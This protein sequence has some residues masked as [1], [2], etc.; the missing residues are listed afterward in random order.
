M[1]RV[2]FA[3]S[4]T[5][6]L[7][8]GGALTAVANRCFAD[9]QQGTFLLRIDDTD[10]E[11]SEVASEQ[12]ILDDLGWLGIEPDAAPIRQSERATLYAKAAA[13]LSE[14]G[15]AAEEDGALRA[16]IA[17]RPTLVRPGGSATYHLASPVDDGALGITHVIRGRDHLSS[18][19]LHAELTSALG[20]PAPEYIH[21]G[22]LVG[23]DGKKLSKRHGASS[24][25]QLRD[26]GVPAEAVR[27][28]LE[29][30][31]LPGHDVRLDAGR[32]E[33]LSIDAIAALSDDELAAR[34]GVGVRLVP[35]VRGARTLVEARAFAAQL[36][37]VPEPEPLSREE[38][39]ALERLIE[40][41]ERAA[42]A[43]DEESARSLLR[44]VKAV[45]GNLR[46]VRT[47]LT[48]ASRGPELWTVLC[49]LDREETIRR[50]EQ[51]L[52]A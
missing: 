27:A 12:G 11:R 40:L 4:P 1:V 41:R 47:V 5:G 46:T 25:K 49:A 33:R 6:A 16:T 30:L 45:G 52:A 51:G 48:G 10:P 24:V 3:P 26:E 44:E 38:K 28:Y 19:E 17:W 50:L 31:D 23:P 35:A 37:T 36:E 9:A 42:A 32:I 13:E 8:L 20:Y 14:R 43:L 18:T 21:H 15:L 22:L 7:H 39:I 34:V 29:E 2:R